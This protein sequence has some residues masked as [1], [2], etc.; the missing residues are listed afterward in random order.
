MANPNPRY[1]A[2]QYVRRQLTEL[3]VEGYDLHERLG[4]DE[5]IIVYPM[6]D[7]AQVSSTNGPIEC[8]YRDCGPCEA[9]HNELPHISE[10]PSP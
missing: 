9:L 5:K 3:G 1:E 2:H 10:G 4:E 7:G 6:K 8:W